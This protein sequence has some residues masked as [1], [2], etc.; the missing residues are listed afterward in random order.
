M[1]GVCGF[2]GE[3]YKLL[4]PEDVSYAKAAHCCQT[5]RPA[6]IPMVG[7]SH[8][9]DDEGKNGGVLKERQRQDK[10]DGG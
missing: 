9:D 7:G 10:G 2:I 1:Y 5:P 4:V 8:L 6:G 3:T